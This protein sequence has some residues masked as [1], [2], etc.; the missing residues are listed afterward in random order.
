MDFEAE[1]LLEGLEGEEREARESLLRQLSDAGVS[2]EELKQ[3]VEEERLALL[4][5]ER[6]LGGEYDLTAADVAERAGVSEDF[7]RR[8]R[9]AL[10]LPL[11][12]D[13]ARAFSEEDITALKNVKQFIDAGLDEEGVEEVT[14]VVGESMSRVA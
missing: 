5:V 7:V 3:A 11:S 4:P 12:S 14:R 9:R 13:N 8:Y 1:G 10:G 2:D 6:A